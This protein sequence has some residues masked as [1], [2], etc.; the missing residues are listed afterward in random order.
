MGDLCV[1]GPGALS[2]DK[3]PPM[4]RRVLVIPLGILVALA[5][6][7]AAL[8]AAGGIPTSIATPLISGVV[9]A[10]LTGG[11]ALT[12]IW[13]NIRYQIDRD[14]IALL[15]DAYTKLLRAGVKVR[16]AHGEMRLF[17][18]GRPYRAPFGF[19]AG[20]PMSEQAQRDWAN[21]N[22][23]EVEERLTEEATDLYTEGETVIYLEQGADSP[24][25]QAWTDLADAFEF[26]RGAILIEEPE[27]AKTLEPRLQTAMIE[28]RRVAHHDLKQLARR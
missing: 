24:V 26:W 7:L 3:M 1:N 27:R 10:M 28:L 12:G 14:R 9:A 22:P 16:D 8:T 4:S 11:L 15:R 23:R 2:A 18:K 19:S 6:L 20:M 17:P 5:L 13:M 21:F 25:L